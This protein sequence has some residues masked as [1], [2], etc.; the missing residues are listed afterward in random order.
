[1]PQVF[2]VRATTFIFFL[3]QAGPCIFAFLTERQQG[4]K[5]ALKMNFLTKAS[6][7]PSRIHIDSESKTEQMSVRP[8][9]TEFRDLLTGAL[10]APILTEP[11]SFDPSRWPPGHRKVSFDLVNYTKS[12]LRKTT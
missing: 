7:P 12:Y 2:A 5:I 6:G 9:V 3:F 1:M 10:A 8:C 4:Y 11:V